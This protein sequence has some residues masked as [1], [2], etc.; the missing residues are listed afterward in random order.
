MYSLAETWISLGL[1]NIGHLPWIYKTRGRLDSYLTSVLAHGRRPSLYSSHPCVSDPSCFIKF[2]ATSTMPSSGSYPRV[3]S[4]CKCELPW[5][6]ILCSA[7]G[8]QRLFCFLRVL[9]PSVVPAGNM[10]ENVG[11]NRFYDVLGDV[12]QETQLSHGRSDIY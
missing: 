6:L 8:L 3:L 12:H 4:P 1:L 7:E 2:V 10:F 11:G 5:W 9:K